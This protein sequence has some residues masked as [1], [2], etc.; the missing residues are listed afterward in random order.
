[1]SN[2]PTESTR[3]FRRQAEEKLALSGETN[4][5]T[6]T[7]IETQRLL[8]ELQV[9]Q[10]ELEMQNEELRRAIAERDEKDALLGTYTD[11]YEFAPVGYFNLDHAGVIHSVNLTGAEL[12]GVE[13][14]Y[15]INNR[16]DAFISD[17]TR[18]GFHDFLEK[19]FVNEA[20]NVC[21][22]VFVTEHRSQIA[23]QIEA[24]VTKSRKVCRAVIIDISAR[25]QTENELAKAN[26]KLEAL[27]TA[28][29]V[30]IS[31]SDDIT[32]QHI[33]G[34]PAVL[35]Q[36]NLS[37]ED[38]LS[39]SSLDPDAPGRKI[40]FIL[41]GREITD[42][43]LPLQ[44][45]VSENQIIPPMELKVVMPNGQHWFAEASAAPVHDAQGEILG[46]IAVTEDITARKLFELRLSENEERMRLVLKASSMG[47]FEIDLVTGETQW[48]SMLFELL[49]LQPDDVEPCPET[50]FRHVHPEDLALVR[51]CWEKALQEGKLDVEFRFVRAD[52]EERWMAGKGEFLFDNQVG[53]DVLKTKRKALKFYGINFDITTRKRS[54]ALQR[55]SDERL[56]YH[57]E[58][59]PMAVVEWDK[60]FV[61][62]RWT[63]ASERMFGWS[64]DEV[65]GKPLADLKMVFD[66]DIP[67]VENTIVQL[68]AVDSQQVVV[69][70]RN[71]TKRGDI[72]YCT[73]YNSVM[74]DQEGQIISV[75][76]Q[77]IDITELKLSQEALSQSQKTLV[78]LV[79]RSPF[80]IYVVDSQFRIAMMNAA[81]LAGPF[82]NVYPA[83]GL[84]FAE[85]MR[86]LWPEDVAAEIID[87]FRHT[88]DTGEAYYS[89]D[90]INP[91][92]D[93]VIVEAYEWQLDRMMLPDGQYGV[94]CYYY[95]STKLR[96]AETKLREKEE[97][98][99][100]LA[101]TML[102]GAVHQ[103]ATGKIISMNPAAEL[104]LGKS[105]EEFLG[106]NSVT[107]EYDTIRENGE[108][109]PG[110]EHPS[111]VA[112]RTGLPVRGVVMG[113]FNPKMD[114][115]RWIDINAV[116]VFRSG[117]NAPS[118]V[119]S[120]FADITDRKLN[121]VRLAEQAEKLHD[122]DLRK[123][124]FLALLAHE[125]RNPLAP[126]RNAVEIQKF[127][128]TDPSRILWC[129]GII[130]RQIN[131]L[132]GL[133]DD[134]LDI[135]RIS[136]GLIELKK[137][138]LEIR[139]FIQP[140]VETNQPLIDIRRQEF[141][142]TLP[143]ES[144]WVEGDRIRLAQVVSNLIN[145][146]AK[147][148][149]EGGRI[150]LSVE[151]SRDD[152]RIG[153]T[154]SGCGIDPAN[155]SSLFDLFYQADR[156]LDRSQGGLGI[157][158]SLV[159][160]LVEK[161]GGDVRAFSSGQGQ[162]SE[163]VIRLPR[164][165]LS[166]PATVFTT[167]LTAPDLKK[168]RILVVDDNQDVAE[169]LALLLEIYGHQVQTANNGFTAL[170]IARAERPDVILLDI[171]LPEMDGYSVARAL[172]QDH[173]L[174]R[175]LLIALTGYGQS[176]DRKKS[177]AAG[178]DAHLVKPV[179][180][181][182][183]RKLLGD[184]T[185]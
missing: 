52:G 163:F 180:I 184:Y 6:P 143:Q 17:E 110:I 126:I 144:V 62:K 95:D 125:L 86:I 136:R 99:R 26:L 166:K 159:R 73:W 113:V 106:M 124:E 31:Y 139:D 44:R 118:E 179:N 93:A 77:V 83:V 47:T 161:H 151:L 142:M 90:F 167:E 34:N 71:Y 162:G 18:P 13:R 174:E 3:K 100:L 72:R 70:N 29:P 37:T 115:Y 98:Y 53:I 49:G 32:C 64:A 148:T 175:T 171:G 130:D 158:L 28:V 84:N 24:V 82:R 9:Q 59:S 177:L 68:T 16:L 75:L 169:S 107:V 42:S 89:R 114:E 150:G 55:E 63:G 66:D 173:G 76:S 103:D 172:R 155:L 88:L 102:Q 135:S 69:T 182:T 46:G 108:I 14:S 116:P 43:E 91:R 119:Y 109:F 67:I 112:L 121:E 39:A 160:S 141:S 122:N 147:Y 35:E 117:E 40:K 153:V 79:E 94:I 132:T 8:H 74:S 157:G 87:H 154:D 131:H 165:I 146:A 168:L 80:G 123:D 11:L 134:L 137:E 164:L 145:N 97:R 60:N 65:V 78:E 2:P 178:F 101:E 12:L 149:E 21:E 129:T 5:E 111:M 127:A 156:H 57:M 30:G 105:R 22:A 181:E 54:E 140:A 138:T 1:M 183:L 27:M 10:I 50:F 58:N 120:V 81:S 61:V 176:D 45:A 185:S 48:N 170:E 96:Q 4:S 152:V 92:Q 7:T 33:T 38:N 36:F 51:T 41:D 15:L 133:V 85:A 25:K 20:K 56:C 128:N 104:I 19:V 23:V